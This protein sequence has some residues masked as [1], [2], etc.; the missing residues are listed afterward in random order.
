[1]PIEA[2]NA[3]AVTTRLV[4]IRKETSPDDPKISDPKNSDGTDFAVDLRRR[5]G[6]KKATKQQV[7]AAKRQSPQRGGFV[8]G[9]VNKA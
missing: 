7:T 5:W 9:S 1:V 2:A 8:A 6:R 4:L 3:N